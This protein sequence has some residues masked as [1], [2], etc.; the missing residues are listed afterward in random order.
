MTGANLIV[1][2]LKPKTDILNDTQPTGTASFQW[3]FNISS[4]PPANL[5]W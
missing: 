5:Y 1:L 2:E 4:Y 3:V